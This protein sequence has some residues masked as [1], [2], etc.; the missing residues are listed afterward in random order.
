[1]L[2]GVYL[3][4]RIARDECDDELLCFPV[5]S[6]MLMN[7]AIVPVIL[8]DALFLAR[9]EHRV[10]AWHRLPVVPTVSTTAGGGKSLVLSGQF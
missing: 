10:E 8:V 4:G 6:I 3:S 5:Q 1:M 7:L 2:A 9:R